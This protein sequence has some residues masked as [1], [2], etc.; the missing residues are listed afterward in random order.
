MS[1]IKLV[2]HTGAQDV[3]VLPSLLRAGRVYRAAHVPFEDAGM[4]LAIYD[5]KAR[6]VSLANG[7]VYPIE[8]FPTYIEVSA[9]LHCKPL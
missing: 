3:T 7:R 4:F 8:H 5:T 9:E 6:V 2:K 1:G